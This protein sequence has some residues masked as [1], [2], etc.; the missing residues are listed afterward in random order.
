[1]LAYVSE[2]TILVANALYG[3][4]CRSDERANDSDINKEDAQARRL[5]IE[6]GKPRRRDQSE[7]GDIGNAKKTERKACHKKRGGHLSDENNVKR[8][9]TVPRENGAANGKV[10][11]PSYN[12]NGNPNGKL[13]NHKKAQNAGEEQDSV[14][15]W[16]HDFAEP[17]HGLGTSSNLTVE[18]VGDSRGRVASKRDIAIHVPAKQDEE[19][20]RKDEPAERDDVG[21]REDLRR[22]IVRASHRVSRDPQRLMLGGVGIGNLLD[23][24]FELVKPSGHFVPLVKAKFL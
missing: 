18:E 13:A 19:N 9:S 7:P 10:Y 12:D 6:A 23:S 21:G 5:G 22:R 20:D 16:V 1:M 17:A 4:N 8:T 15:Y 14:H 24:F 11:V 3:I 2:T